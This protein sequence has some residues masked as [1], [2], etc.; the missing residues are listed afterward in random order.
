MTHDR[1]G[2]THLSPKDHETIGSAG[3][4]RPDSNGRPQDPTTAEQR[5]AANHT[6]MT[7]THKPK[8]SPHEIKKAMGGE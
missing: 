8:P 4:K 5:D 1:S 2:S 3:R 6:R 7:V